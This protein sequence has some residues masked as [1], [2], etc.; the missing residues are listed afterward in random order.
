MKYLSF[1][2]III[3]VLVCSCQNKPTVHARTITEAMAY[4]GVSNYCHTH[5]DWSIAEENPSIMSVQMGEET[6]TE[7]QVVFRSYTS[8]LVYFYVNKSSGTT[9]MIEYVPALDIENEVG[10]F[11]LFE[12]VVRQ[13]LT[14]P[15][16]DDA[17]EVDKSKNY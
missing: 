11:D 10:T 8:A 3:T 17:P 4:Q 15:A 2:F 5:Y 7:Y 13:T 1:I 6:E 9:R 16:D 14:L 12:Y